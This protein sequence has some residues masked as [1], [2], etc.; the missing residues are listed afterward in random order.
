MEVGNHFSVVVTHA[1]WQEYFGGASD[2]VGRELRI[3]ARSY[4]VVGVLPPDF[5]LPNQADARIFLPIA[6]TE[7]QRQLDAWHS[8]NYQSSS[9]RTF[10]FRFRDEKTGL[11]KSDMLVSR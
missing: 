1:Y 9:E 6:F 5:V 2:V 8:N 7:E 3:N 10:N 11:P 4:T